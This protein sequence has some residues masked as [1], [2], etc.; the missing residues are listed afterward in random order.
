MKEFDVY[1]S[2]TY[3]S[4][5]EKSG[6][7]GA[8]EINE[9]IIKILIQNCLFE[10]M[11][12]TNYGGCIYASVS[13]SQ[14]K[15]NSFYKCQTTS[16]E[17]E[18]FGNAAYFPTG[19]SSFYS[20]SFENCSPNNQNGDSA[21]V[22]RDSS[23]AQYMNMSNNGGRSG[24]SGFM[25]FSTKDEETYISYINV[26]KPFD[27]VAFGTQSQLITEHSNIID[28]T[29]LLSS[30][31]FE[32]SDLLMTFKLCVFLNSHE[33]FSYKDM[34]YNLIDCYSDKK[35]NSISTTTEAN[36]IDFTIPK[37][38]SIIFCV[39][40]HKNAQTLGLLKL[41]SICILEKKQ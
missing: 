14:I 13:N 21:Y 30:I 32:S 25:T 17:D 36:T 5:I 27:F 29:Q 3:F 1:V 12:V 7:G 28:T 39:T 15:F 23:K 35:F 10:M 26:I 33:K 34:K 16:T 2:S 11:K 31:I 41:L 40:F 4:N 6:N 22:V 20:S 19:I 24:A 37:L 38:E 18:T 9:N 8:I